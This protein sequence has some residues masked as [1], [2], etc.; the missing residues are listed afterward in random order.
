MPTGAPMAI[1]GQRY[2]RRLPAD[3][4]GNLAAEE[5]QHLQQSGLSAPPRDADQQ[6][7]RH[8]GGT[9][10]RQSHP[11][12]QREVDCLTEVDQRGRLS[13]PVGK[14]AVLADVLR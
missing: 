10:Q 7:V 6:Q 14:S 5:S 13:R 3:N 2:R 4:R 8:R 1:P 9:E 12:K 11:E